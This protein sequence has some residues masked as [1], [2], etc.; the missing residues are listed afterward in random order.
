MSF[1]PRRIGMFSLLLGA[2][3][4]LMLAGL[5]AASSALRAGDTE[6]LTLDA[7]TSA[8]LVETRLSALSDAL[9]TLAPGMTRDSTHNRR[10]LSALTAAMV[11]RH[12]ELDRVLVALPSGQV[13]L[14]TVIHE[15]AGTLVLPVEPGVA[16]SA[17]L[18]LLDRRHVVL[19]V[20]LT[21]DSVSEGTALAV[22]T[23]DAMLSPVAE[24]APQG[25]R[26]IGI[27]AGADTIARI[28]AAD[29]PAK[30]DW[31]GTQLR[32]PG[33]THWTLEVAH[34]RRIRELRLALWLLALLA[35]VFLFSGLLWERRQAIRV[36]ERSAEL[37]RLS[38]ELLRANRMKSEFLANVSHELRTPLNAIVGFVELLRDGVY[39]ELSPRQA[40]PVD[41]IAGSA[42]HLR[43]LVDQVLDIA[44]MAA[45]RL[46]V[47]PEQ[48]VLR[49]FVLNVASEL[50]SLVA[51]RGLALSIAVGTTLPRVRTDPA[52]LRQILV[53]LLAN[54][55]KY[56]PEGGI[57]VRARLVDG[58]S[59]GS[60]IGCPDLS[61][62]WVAVQVSDTGLGIA[63]AD[64]ERIF[65]E[66][67]QVNAGPRGDSSQRGTG[68][69]LPISRRL[70]RLL[71][72]EITLE[73]EPGRGSTFTIWLPVDRADVQVA[74][75]RVSPASATK[76]VVE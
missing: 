14:D 75:E 26:F 64:H 55:V 36:A 49:A 16:A 1:A 39:G 59:A 2:V 23:S 60:P 58:T 24:G 30:I 57:T 63:L 76:A 40:S 65:D 31:F 21:F 3:L 69:G 13:V 20:P 5:L 4:L 35:L 51:E 54:A 22:F 56:T 18:P 10:A 43:H 15:I 42:T 29:Q 70:T 6:H 52:H 44:K 50:E 66:F 53:N 34:A 7:S 25:R 73:S 11:A 46:E 32:V 67:E 71:G 8:R 45:G 62:P 12:P 9:Q 27:L 38:A 74:K 37:E 72:G 28:G 33:G 61:R 68:L 48:V 47:H 41:R 19:R 17:L